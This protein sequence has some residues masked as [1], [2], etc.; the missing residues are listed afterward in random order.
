MTDD[1]TPAKFLSLLH[2]PVVIDRRTERV[3]LLVG[4]AALFAGYDV[5]IFGLAT[6][7]IQ[8]ALNIP[9]NQVG[10]TLA[11]FRT[12]AVMALLIAASADLIGR[13]RLL[14]ATIF[15]QAI[16]TLATAFAP[17]Y[18]SFVAAQ[19]FTRIFGYAEEMLCFVVVAEE[20]A[21]GA[22]GWANSA[23]VAFYFVGAGLASAFFAMIEILPYGWRALYFL[24]AIP[25]FL[26]G[27]L[28]RR[29]PETKRFE[30]QRKSGLGVS[31]LLAL[32]RDI[33]VQYPLRVFTAISAAG[34]FGFAAAPATFLAQKYLQEAYHYSPGQTSLVLIPGGLLGLGLAIMAGRLS[35]RIGRKPVA[36]TM[37]GLCGIGFFLFFGHGPAWAAPIL[38]ITAFLGYFSGETLI[39]G[40]A[41]EIVPTHYRAT[42]GGL[43]YLVE[44]GAGAAA[45]ALEGALYDGFHNHGPAL[46]WLLVSLPIAM[47]ALLLLPE[48]AGKSLEELAADA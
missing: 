22:R 37:V 47:G 9:E 28:R 44:I 12:A 24:G 34:A 8:H 32:L 19:I 5:N 25:L 45:L 38:W 18:L 39:A 41:L 16:F 40:Y 33:A 36:I 17:N 7:Q 1:G 23:L 21:A 14:L 3:M 11:Y 42:I 4:A 15:G 6:P 10:L 46:Q 29:L 27:V 35:D 20:I 31:A 30:N 26:V 43:R 2:P 48:P 13:R